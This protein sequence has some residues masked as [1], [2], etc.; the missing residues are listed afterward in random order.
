MEPRGLGTQPSRSSKIPGNPS[1][2]PGY[3]SE[4]PRNQ[5]ENPRNQSKIPGDQSRNPRNQSAVI[6]KQRA[7][8]APE[9]GDRQVSEAA[10]P[11]QRGVLSGLHP[12]SG[13]EAK[14]QPRI[15]LIQQDTGSDHQLINFET[16]Q[17]FEVLQLHSDTDNESL[18]SGLGF[19][20]GDSA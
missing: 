13:V 10:R 18:G 11:F 3:Q 15:D 14:R 8:S 4:N 12:L 6:T 5:S 9:G 20:V 16:E 7:R 2:I 1:T 19:R 17:D